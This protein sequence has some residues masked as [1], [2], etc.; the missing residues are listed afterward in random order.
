M[1]TEG[2]VIIILFVDSL[3]TTANIR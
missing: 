1:E 3:W 2:V